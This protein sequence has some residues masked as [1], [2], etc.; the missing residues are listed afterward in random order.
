MNY[1]YACL[2]APGPELVNGLSMH[3]NGVVDFAKAKAQ[4]QNYV[5]ALHSAGVKTTVCP[6]DSR[7]ADGCFVEDTHLVLPEIT[8]RLNPGAPPRQHEPDGLRDALPSDRPYERMPLSFGID[9]GDILVLGQNIYV[10]L[11]SRTKPE[12]VKHMAAL[13]APLGYHVEA[14]EVP[15]SLHLKSGVTAIDENTLVALESFASVIGQPDLETFIVPEQESRGANVVALH[16]HV[17][18]PPGCPTLRAFIE[19]RRPD[20]IIIEVDTSEF[21]KLDGALT[22]L[23]ILW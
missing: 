6:A 3:A 15:Q 8:I 9:G 5:A 21:A 12:A 23:S 20:Q 7:F 14:V 19:S 10:G 1:Q 11:S 16:S 4:H 17:L 18:I 13:L 22:C 2:R